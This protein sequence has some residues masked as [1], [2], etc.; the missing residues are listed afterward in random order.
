MDVKIAEYCE[1]WDLDVD[2]MDIDEF[3][4]HA[5]KVEKRW[6]KQKLV[7]ALIVKPSRW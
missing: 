5:L 4:R 2:T 1:D 7:A 6:F 3:F